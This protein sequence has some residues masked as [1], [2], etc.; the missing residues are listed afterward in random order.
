[1]KYKLNLELP[2]ADELTEGLDLHDVYPALADAER[3]LQ[4][5]A[6]QLGEARAEFAR[7]GQQAESLARQIRIGE[8]TTRSLDETLLARGRVALELKSLEVAV[9]AAKSKLPATRKAA[10]AAREELIAS[11]RIELQKVADQLAPVLHAL[12]AADGELERGRGAVFVQ[13]GASVG[14]PLTWPTARFEARRAKGMAAATARRAAD[15]AEA[16]RVA[17]ENAAQIAATRPPNG[18]RG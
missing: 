4:S 12:N 15:R 13:R 1:M 5:A 16:D 17:A 7:L 2:S 10:V 14:P 9:T 8:A 18:R 6:D 3:E 11:R